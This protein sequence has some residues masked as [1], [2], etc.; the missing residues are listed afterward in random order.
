[1]FEER[2]LNTARQI[3]DQAR[4]QGKKLAFAES[5][6][7]GLLTALFTEVPGSS[8]VIDRSFVTYSNRSK[9]EMLAV[10][11]EVIADLGAVSESVAKAMANG[12]LNEA[13][14]DLT[15]AIT[16]IAGPGGGTPLKPVGLVHIAVASKTEPILHEAHNFGNIGRW[17]VRRMS[18]IKAMDLLLVR[19]QS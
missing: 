14:A 19:L 13:R 1:M 16:G 11:G 2:L 5:C 10:S 15:V 3:L 9:Q 4:H 18:M 17:Q 6:T 12:V 8:S 7:G